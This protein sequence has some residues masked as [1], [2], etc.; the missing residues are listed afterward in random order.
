MR[1]GS[2]AN[3]SA[4]IRQDL[5]DKIIGKEID[6]YL[7][8]PANIDD[9][10]A[11]FE[12]RSRK[13]GDFVTNDTFKDALNNAVRSQRL[14]DANIDETKLE[15]LSSEVNFDAKGVDERGKEKDSTGL[16]IASFIIG[17]MIYITLTIYG[18]AIMGAVV[19][20]KETRIAEILFSS[21]RPFTLMMG[22]LVGV[23]LAGLTQLAIWI[24]SAV[25]IL[26][27][28]LVQVDTG[29]SLDSIPSITPLMII[30][31]LV[32]FLLGFFIYASIFALI[33]S[34]V[35]TLQEG[36]QFSFPPV[37]ILLIGFYFSF[38]VIRDPSSTL[39]FWA[40]IAPFFAPITMPV[41]ILAET[42][43][44]W[45]I[46]LAFVVNGL[47]IAG[48]VWL[49]ARVYRVGMLMYGKRATIPEVWKWIRQE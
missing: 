17:L 4:A 47:A 37:M 16:M 48:L 40:S 15:Q 9:P 42:P 35:T 12:F 7:I 8:V 6:A 25:V 28:L 23:G 10:N 49:T 20:E 5:T 3:R 24:T 34:M 1:L 2:C 44:F 41:R 31:F 13:G 22:K 21:A 18:Q 45:Q 39:S 26:T 38:A 32:F 33:G 11:V 36:S 29:L 43:P 46:G 19:E 27:I 30:Y 14:A